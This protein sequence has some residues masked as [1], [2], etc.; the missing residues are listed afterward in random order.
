M[1][2]NKLN[3]SYKPKRILYYMEPTLEEIDNFKKGVIPSNLSIYTDQFGIYDDVGLFYVSSLKKSV[4]GIEFKLDDKNV[5]YPKNLKSIILDE[6]YFYSVEIDDDFNLSLDNVLAF[7]KEIGKDDDAKR[8]Y[9]SLTYKPNPS[10][11]SMFNGKDK[12]RLLHEWNIDCCNSLD[13]IEDNKDKL[14]IDMLYKLA[15]IDP[16]TSHY[17]WNH[18][19]PFLETP[20]LKGIKDYA[21]V[22]FDVKEFRIINEVYGHIA[23]NKVLCNIVKKMKES[24]FVYASARCHNDNFAMMIKDMPEEETKET[25]KKFFSDL[26][27]LEEDPNYRIYYRCGVVPMKRSMLSGN[28][29]ADFGKYAQ[30]LNKNSNRETDI[31]FYADSMHDDM[32]WGNYIKA[33][34]DTAIQNDEFVVYLQPK[35][36]I[37]NEKLEGSEALVRWNYELKTMLSPGRFIPF[38]EKDYS[39][40]KIDDIV[41]EKVCMALNKWEK[42]GKKLYPVSV[43]LSR[44]RLFEPNLISHLTSIVDKYNIDHHLIDFELTES[45]SYTNKDK[46]LDCLS[47]LRKLNFKTSMDDFGT[48]YSSLSLLKEMPLDTL[49]ID[50]S[51]VDNLGT[52][53]E[54]EKDIIVLKHIISLAKNLSFSCLAEGAEL[55][56]QVDK[57]R[58]L[59]C[60]IIQGYYYSKP[61]SIDDFEK[62][63]LN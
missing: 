15:F 61:I 31:N 13:I 50:K 26:S 9:S 17:N 59:G 6:M 24:D 46:M 10:I 54:N 57:L 39:I 62:K 35:F 5:K 25:L 1:Y 43:N 40:G 2:I 23:A 41:L 22:H 42:E 55:K 52:D 29:V 19:L 21:F 38:F 48:G 30:A 3:Q 47:E 18:L 12:R 63:Y 16:I 33:Y 28:R 58:S 32:L 7:F 56:S 4:I 53:K 51:F 34:L 14:D 20:N 11:I 49:K 60:E 37:I 44:N 27:K 45:A 8:I 36:D